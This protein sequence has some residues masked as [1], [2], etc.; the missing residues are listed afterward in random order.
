[1]RTVPTSYV[2]NVKTKTIP[3]KLI[4]NTK[5]RWVGDNDTDDEKSCSRYIK[6]ELKL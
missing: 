6:Q 5:D 2:Y 1:M 4:P 3:T